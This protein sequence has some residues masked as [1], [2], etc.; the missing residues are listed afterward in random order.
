M[1]DLSEQLA[2]VQ[3][4][5]DIIFVDGGSNDG[6]FDKLSEIAARAE[7]APQ[8]ATV[9]VI[10]SG[11]GRAQQMNQGAALSRSD[12]LVFLHADTRLPVDALSG[13]TAAYHSGRAWG[14]FDVKF[15]VPGGVMRLIAW[16]MNQRSALTGIATGDQAIFV[17]RDI[18]Q[19]IGGYPRIPLMED[20]ALSRRLKHISR[21]YRIQTP[22]TTA[23]R[24]WQAQGVF[25]TIGH[26]WCNRLLYWVGVSP[27]RLAAR[28]RDVR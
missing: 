20:I 28:Y 6:T 17:R 2:T 15:D 7:N 4:I 12:M 22:V 11:P 25:T 13:L 16:F 24:R 19:Q 1:Q 5:S 27:S 21:P 3:G 26:M 8:A 18:F 23:A 14:R 9:R 10:T